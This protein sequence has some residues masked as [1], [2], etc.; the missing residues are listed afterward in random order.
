MVLQPVYRTRF[1]LR[2]RPDTLA[3]HCS[4]PRYQAHFQEFLHEHLGLD[5]Y[6]LIAVPG[7]PQCLTLTDYL[8]KFAWVGWRWVRFLVE[9]ANPSRVVLI[10]HEGCRWY[11]DGRF[12][13]VGSGD[14]AHQL[15]D[16]AQVRA[17]LHGRFTNVSVEAYL[18]SLDGE[19]VVFESAD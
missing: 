8:P 10:T 9:V 14:R 4:D 6:E 1:E 11:G 2:K 7:G 18:A 16:L 12:A 15:R 3:I 17:E 5:S 19:H 13:V